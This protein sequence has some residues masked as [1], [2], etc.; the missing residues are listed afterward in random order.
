[1]RCRIV[2]LKDDGTIQVVLERAVSSTG[3]VLLPP[4]FEADANTI[5]AIRPSSRTAGSLR[6]QPSGDRIDGPCTA[7]RT[8]PVRDVVMG[9]Q[10]ADVDVVGTHLWLSVTAVPVCLVVDGP[11]TV[12]LVISVVTGSRVTALRLVEAEANFR[13]RGAAP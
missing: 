7:G 2:N 10:R 9:V 12:L 6:R 1:M 3:S 13:R 4:G 11:S 8:P 5:R